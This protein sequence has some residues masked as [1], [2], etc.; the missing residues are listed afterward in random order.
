VG[1]W[2]RREG[3]PTKWYTRF[4]AYRLM[5]S[6]RSLLGTVN[7]EPGKEG[8]K[9]TSQNI[10]NSW[11]TAAEKW[12]WKVRA[13][14]WDM[15]EARREA[16]A[17]AAWKEREWAEEEQA[18]IEW[19]AKRKQ[20]AQGL[21][22]KAAEALTKLGK[23]ESIGTLSQVANTV[24]IVLGELRAEFD[25]L[26]TQRGEFTGPGGGPIEITAVPY[27]EDEL[28]EWRQRQRRDLQNAKALSG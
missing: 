16:A 12:E 6:N 9:R 11:R 17:V 2:D 8:Q 19:R 25:D 1:E 21:F 10:P 28:T 22:S 20:L 4:E 14:A 7:S 27:A 5:G 26:P 23:D 3:E 13:E 18:R 15:R 24:K